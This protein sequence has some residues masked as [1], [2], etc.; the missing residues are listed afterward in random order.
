VELTV[1]GS[2]SAY[3]APGGAASGYLVRHDGFNLVMDF[4][5]GALSNVQR[6]VP[7]TKIDAL[8]ISH[9]HPDHCLDLYP[10]WLALFF[11]PEGV[12]PI[13]LVAPAGVFDRVA[14]L[15]RNQD[16]VRDMGERF[17]VQEVDPGAAVEL[18]PFRVQTRP[19][20]HL[21]TTIGVRVE[22]DGRSL[23][24]TGDTGPTE[25]IEHL[26]R[27]ADV[28]LAES[29][30]LDGQGTGPFH[31]TAREAGGHAARAEAGRLV[32]SHFWPTNEREPSR[33]QASEA[34]DRD[35]VLAEEGMG[36]E[37]AT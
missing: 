31:L 1:L 36:I 10:L 4:G 35:V 26:A 34:F 19:M 24:Y 20:R 3:P 23:A 13:P 8:V 25:E 15:H 28:L 22:A 33:D 29:T 18:G 32:L 37:V 16:E 7:L 14:R 5:T 2:S 21:V 17:A 12:P 6:H 9:E 27:G 11:H 30:W